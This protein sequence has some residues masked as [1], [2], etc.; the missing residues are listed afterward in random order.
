LSAEV[1]AV[2][3]AG[4][5]AGGVAAWGSEGG[6]AGC[7]GVDCADAAKLIVQARIAAAIANV[8]AFIALIILVITSPVDTHPRTCDFA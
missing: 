1:S 3:E 4:V 7:W 8:G 5:E 6:L 2:V